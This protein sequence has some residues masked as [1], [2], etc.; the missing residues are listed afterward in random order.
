VRYS[1]FHLVFVSSSLGKHFP[2]LPPFQDFPP[3]IGCNP[4]QVHLG[5]NHFPLPLQSPVRHKTKPYFRCRP[6][7]AAGPFPFA[8]SPSTIL[9]FWSI[10]GSC[11]PYLL[12][13]RRPSSMGISRKEVHLS[14]VR[15][16]P[17]LLFRDATIGPPK[18]DKCLCRG[19][20]IF[21]VFFFLR[22]R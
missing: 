15:S 19:A 1:T 4:P 16:S 7:G 8:F 12:F 22:G 10:N 3:P 11:P 9:V 20:A 18:L 21:M 6:I 5:R 13:H 2:C 14:P 17:P